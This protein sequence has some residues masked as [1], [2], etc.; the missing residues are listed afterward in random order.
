MS[1]QQKTA[2]RMGGVPELAIFSYGFLVA[3]AGAVGKALRGGHE[4][5]QP[6][7]GIGEMTPALVGA[8]G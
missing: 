8:L 3:H 1:R 2:V 7:P 6:C 4:G 5:R